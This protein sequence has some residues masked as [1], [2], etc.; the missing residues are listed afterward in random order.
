MPQG[1]PLTILHVDMD[2]FYA[3]V[4]VRDNPSLA[5]LPMTGSLVARTSATADIPAGACFCGRRC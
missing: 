4:E 1:P 5:G 2:A 3:S